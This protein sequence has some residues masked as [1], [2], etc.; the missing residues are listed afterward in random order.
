MS[1]GLLKYF[2]IIVLFGFNISF[3]KWLIQRVNFLDGLSISHSDC[4]L[5]VR[6]VLIFVIFISVSF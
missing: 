4:S 5:H 6:I 1:V 3:S 2:V